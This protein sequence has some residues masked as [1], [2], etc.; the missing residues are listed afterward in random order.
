MATLYLQKNI[1]N[2]M[3]LYYLSQIRHSAVFEIKFVI[4]CIP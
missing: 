4:Y 2:G 1:A 3:H